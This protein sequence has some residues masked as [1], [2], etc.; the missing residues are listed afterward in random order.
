M[1]SQAQFWNR[2]ARKYA[3]D[4]IADL[5]GYEASLARVRSLL[6]PGHTVLEVG[7]G[8][9]STALRLAGSVRSYLGTDLA[10]EMVTIAH[11]RLAQQPTPG[12]HFGVADAAAP[13]GTA[14][15]RF[16]VLLAF[17]LLHL[18]PDLGDSLAHL[19][20]PLQ[21]GGLFISKTACLGEMNPLVPWLAV[22]V[23]RLLG[24]APPV[25]V[26]K[27]AALV[28]ALERQGLQIESI[29]RHGTRGR[30]IRVFIVAR[31]P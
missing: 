10:A 29:E 30:D 4:T 14:A 1:I 25:R 11:E 7:C 28:A 31:K 13:Q 24:K 27:Q 26:F 12:L 16:D 22:P 19:L 3:A 23:A 6:R 9:G 5:P 8:T 20:Q 2:I 15:A 17:N 18:L 21:P